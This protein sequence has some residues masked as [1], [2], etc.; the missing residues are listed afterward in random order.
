M[1]HPITCVNCHGPK[2]KGDRVYMMMAYAEPF[3]TPNITWDVLTQA[4][5]HGAEA[6]EAEH[7]EHPPYTE[8]TLKKAIT[9]GVN[10]ADEPLDN[11][12]PLWKMSEQD[13]DDLIEFIKTLE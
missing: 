6:G 10:P 11:V 8:E 5:E 12:M 2:G 9:R 13:L 3:G 7:E 1:M 4:K